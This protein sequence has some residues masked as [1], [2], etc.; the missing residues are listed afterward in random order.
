MMTDD[1]IKAMRDA[2]MTADEVR[3]ARA[4][5]DA[6]FAEVKPWM[7]GWD[8]REVE[9]RHPTMFLHTDCHPLWCPVA[10]ADYTAAAD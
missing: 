1:E 8:L 4:E 2:T 7:T 6:A 10:A 3:A 5:I 9:R